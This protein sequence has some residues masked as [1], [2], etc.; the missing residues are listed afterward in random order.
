MI[1]GPLVLLG[2]A[3]SPAGRLHAVRPRTRTPI[4]CAAV[5]TDL[6]VVERTKAFL[7][8]GTGYYSPVDAEALDDTFVFRAPSIG[9]LN[10]ADYMNTMTNLQTYQ[11]YPDL[12]P[13][14][15]GFTVD[16]SNPLKCIFWTRATGTFSE[17]WNP[18][19]AKLEVAK[20]SPNGKKAELPTECYSATWTADGK[21]K[22][23]TAGY[24]VNRFEGNT[25][26]L[27]AVLALFYNA[28]LPQMASI[29]LN[30][31]VRAATNWLANNVD[32][33]LAKTASNPEDLPAWY[34]E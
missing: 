12:N 8:T 14:A 33:S 15:F 7:Q 31:N 30:E 3:Y 9:P 21:L 17:P 28:D 25:G 16:P 10:K 4:A 22:F 1:P 19:G 23:L 13:N 34:S 20:I 29:A 11:G 32:T 26:G 6:D 5:A 2:L 24:V 27:G 18:F